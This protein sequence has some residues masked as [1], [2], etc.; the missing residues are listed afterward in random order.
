MTGSLNSKRNVS[1]LYRHDSHAEGIN[2]NVFSEIHSD[3][4]L[5]EI[6]LLKG[7]SPVERM[8]APAARARCLRNEALASLRQS[9]LR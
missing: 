2:P 1:T 3:P 7:W 9:E 6:C 4:E 5:D 8:N